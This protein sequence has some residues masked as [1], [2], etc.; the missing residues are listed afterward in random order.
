MSKF[1][2]FNPETQ[3]M[4][5]SEEVGL[6]E[7]FYGDHNV[8]TIMKHT[9]HRDAN[10]VDIY[11]HDIVDGNGNGRGVV[12][13]LPKDEEFVVATGIETSFDVDDPHGVVI[14]N[15]VQHKDLVR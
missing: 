12:T 9:G 15:Y 1:R 14:G 2:R 5:Y 11:Q 13:W 7:F 4:V 10:G 6:Y 3:E 8:A